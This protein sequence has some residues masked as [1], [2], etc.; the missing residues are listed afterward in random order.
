MALQLGRP[1]GIQDRD[2]DV[3]LPLNIDVDYT[4]SNAIFV[5]QNHQIELNNGKRP[6]DEYENGYESITSVSRPRMDSCS[7]LADTDTNLDDIIHP[8]RPF[9]SAQAG[10]TGCHLP[11]RNASEIIE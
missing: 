8:Q 7:A 3:E 5:M 2:I 6:G 1:C 11:S 4:D 10:Y 9:E